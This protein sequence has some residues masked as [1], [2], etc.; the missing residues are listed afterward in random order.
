MTAKRLKGSAGEF[1]VMAELAYRGYNITRPHVDIGVDLEARDPTTWDLYE[2]QVKT[3]TANKVGDRYRCSFTCNRAQL[4]KEKPS[5]MLRYV[6]VTRIRSF[7]HFIVIRRSSLAEIAEST[8]RAARNA[9]SFTLNAYFFKDADG[10]WTVTR[11]SIEECD[12]LSRY[13]ERWAIF[14][15]CD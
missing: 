11:S 14:P 8:S 4:F 15:Y 6:L 10:R 2:V 3:S 13:Y 1:A 5:R 12:D 7:F 9:K